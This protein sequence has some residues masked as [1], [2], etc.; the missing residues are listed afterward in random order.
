MSS[1]TMMNNAHAL[2]QH[3]HAKI[4]SSSIQDDVDTLHI[5]DS[6][7]CLASSSLMNHQKRYT[8]DDTIHNQDTEHNN[9][10]DVIS[11]NI[12][13]DTKNK[14]ISTPA[15]K[16][17]KD[18]ARAA[19]ARSR[20]RKKTWINELEQAFYMLKEN[21]LILEEMNTNLIQLIHDANTICSMIERNR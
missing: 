2:Q 14:K 12:I 18:V 7:L 20:K 21:N 5:G 19:A 3:Y 13:I 6:K 17:R 11:T 4:T 8:E 9:S 16:K 1:M 15:S 10:Q